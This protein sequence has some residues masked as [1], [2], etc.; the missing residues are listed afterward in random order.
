MPLASEEI[1]ST[2]IKLAWEYIGMGLLCFPTNSQKPLLHSF[3]AVNVKANA[4]TYSIQH[5]AYILQCAEKLDT[6]ICHKRRKSLTKIYQSFFTPKCLLS[7]FR[8]KHF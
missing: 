6:T 5:T 1:T 2:A 4:K 7:P 3:T 8:E